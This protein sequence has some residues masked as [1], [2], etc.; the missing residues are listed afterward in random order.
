[1]VTCGK[2]GKE[3]EEEAGP[4]VVSVA[5]GMAG[6]GKRRDARVRGRVFLPVPRGDGAPVSPHSAW[7]AVGEPPRPSGFC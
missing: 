3:D 7:R 4:P 6:C 5:P 2:E 1:M